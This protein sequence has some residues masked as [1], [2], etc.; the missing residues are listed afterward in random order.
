MT[1]ENT[2]TG[3]ASE[4]SAG[5]GLRAEQ[6]RDG[7]LAALE[8]LAIVETENRRLLDIIGEV[9]SWAVCACIATPE[10]M[11]QNISRIVEITRPNVK[12]TN[13]APTKGN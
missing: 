13:A 7:R 4:L 5:L 8:A 6:H 11:M 2:P 10:E 9:H 12:L 1:N 3:A